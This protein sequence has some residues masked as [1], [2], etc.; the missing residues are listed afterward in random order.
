MHSLRRKV[1]AN[2]AR[3]DFGFV[4]SVSSPCLNAFSKRQG[5]DTTD[6]SRPCM[7]YRHVHTREYSAYCKSSSDSLR[8]QLQRSCHPRRLAPVR[9]RAPQHTPLT[10]RRLL[11]VR[12]P[13]SR[14]PIPA[15]SSLSTTLQTPLPLNL[16]LPVAGLTRPVTRRASTQCQTSR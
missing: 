2:F 12:Q 5:R 4:G 6:V 13:T 8:M 15:A 16:L 3:F 9:R 11:T 10:W 1:R 7:F 14:S